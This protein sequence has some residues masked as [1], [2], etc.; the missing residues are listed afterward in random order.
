MGA[1]RERKYVLAGTDCFG[2]SI[3]DVLKVR[4]TRKA[5]VIT[6]YREEE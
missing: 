3:H 5:V 6:V 4:P 1:N 2:D